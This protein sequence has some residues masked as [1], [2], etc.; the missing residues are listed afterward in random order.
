[1][2]ALKPDRNMASWLWLGFTCNKRILN[3]HTFFQLLRCYLG[4]NCVFYAILDSK[5]ELNWQEHSA[6]H[7]TTAIHCLSGA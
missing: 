2:N 7:P 4:Q 3:S 1:M 5:S 6:A